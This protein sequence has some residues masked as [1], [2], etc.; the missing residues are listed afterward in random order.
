MPV[1]ASIVF[2]GCANMQSSTQR[3][4]KDLLVTLSYP[5]HAPFASAMD[6][7]EEIKE[8]PLTAIPASPLIFTAEFVK[9]TYAT[10]PYLADAPFYPL[11]LFFGP[12]PI[13]IYDTKEF[14][15]KLQ[16]E[17]LQGGG[18]RAARSAMALVCSPVASAL[19][20]SKDAATYWNSQPVLRYTHTPL[21]VPFQYTKH[22]LYSLVYGLDYAFFP[23]C[24][25][26]KSEPMNLYDW[27]QYPFY[28]EPPLN[29]TAN[30]FYKDANV[31]LFAPFGIPAHTGA[32]IGRFY[33]KHPVAA[34]I[35]AP[36]YAPFLLI[37]HTTYHFVYILDAVFYPFYFLNLTGMTDTYELYITGELQTHP[38]QEKILGQQLIGSMIIIMSATAQAAAQYNYQNNPTQYNY[39]QVQ[40]TQRDSQANTIVAG[41]YFQQAEAMQEAL[42]NVR[43][44][45]RPKT[46]MEFLRYLGQGREEMEKLEQGPEL[47]RADATGGA[48]PR[49]MQRYR[50]VMNEVLYHRELKL[51]DECRKEILQNFGSLELPPSNVN[52]LSTQQDI[53]LILK[54][55]DELMQAYMAIPGT[56]AASVMMEDQLALA[57]DR[58]LDLIDQELKKDDSPWSSM[59]K[60]WRKKVVHIKHRDY[61]QDIIMV[62]IRK[63]LVEGYLTI[64]EFQAVQSAH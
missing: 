49:M 3:V 2:T 57:C 27:D 44:F 13:E 59:M 16:S 52:A 54:I 10:V 47:T 34:V 24:M 12:K 36:F 38:V 9:H 30:R 55:Q 53:E 42:R 41:T 48:S 21:L 63:L 62:E 8:K 5:V 39:Q 32:D 28:V 7:A 40:T 6:T 61:T 4:G 64:Y 20:T 22:W 18:R 15:Y 29:K 58:I 51:F 56:R 46:A 14:P 19:G 26:F 43:G 37:K 17:Q 31:A 50:D 25:L 23:L 11:Y 60:R 35:T 45:R 1:L 33:Q